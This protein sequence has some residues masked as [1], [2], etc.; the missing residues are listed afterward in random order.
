MAKLLWSAR[1]RPVRVHSGR[2]SAL[3]LLASLGAGCSANTVRTA[4]PAV[5]GSTTNQQ[6]IMMAQTHS[7]ATAVAVAPAL[8]TG[9][10][11]AQP[12]PALAGSHAAIAPASLTPDAPQPYVPPKPWAAKDLPTPVG[13]VGLQEPR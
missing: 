10:V 9:G 2:V 6:R 13:V 11:V 7:S 5:T 3:A 4:E 12:L 8:P 1:L